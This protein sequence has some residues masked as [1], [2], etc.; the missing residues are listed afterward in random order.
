MIIKL[1]FSWDKTPEERKAQMQ[2]VED[3]VLTHFPHRCLFPYAP[4]DPK[5]PSFV[6]RLVSEFGNRAVDYDAVLE[7]YAIDL[8]RR[9]A[10][11]KGYCYF[12]D[13]DDH[14]AAMMMFE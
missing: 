2:A 10:N 14:L 9:R 7:V 6:D 5:F 12:R 13:P 8:D 4:S 1:P 11:W 3:T